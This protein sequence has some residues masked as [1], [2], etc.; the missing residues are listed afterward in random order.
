MPSNN[1]KKRPI[2]K[3]ALAERKSR[4]YEQP[5]NEKS[6]LKLLEARREQLRSSSMPEMET[7]LLEVQRTK[8]SRP[9]SAANDTSQDKVKFK[10]LLHCMLAG[11]W[12]SALGR[13]SNLEEKSPELSQSNVNI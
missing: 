3:V 11:E 13:M 8:Q 2:V 1:K 10:T 5:T 9:H 4:V 7:K 12:M 6:E